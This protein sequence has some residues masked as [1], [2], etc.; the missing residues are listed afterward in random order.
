[1]SGSERCG[2][3]AE[4]AAVRC[5]GL[6]LLR[7]SASANRRL[8]P[9]CLR[10]PSTGIS[11]GISRVG[12]I[13]TMRSRTHGAWVALY[14]ERSLQGTWHTHCCCCL[15]EKIR[16]LTHRS[17][18]LWWCWALVLQVLLQENCFDVTS[19]VALLAGG[20]EVFWGRLWCWPP[21]KAKLY[22]HRGEP[23]HCVATT[24]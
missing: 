10:G 16:K 4:A 15:I 22:R 1:M 17:T 12:D 19:V 13:A 5:G 14:V 18:G 11:T 24:F 6:P 2:G 3:C 20:E 21:S 8:L 9:Y 23:R 7:A